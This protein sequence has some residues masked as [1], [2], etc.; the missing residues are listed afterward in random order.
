MQIWR[1]N[2]TKWCYCIECF[3]NYYYMETLAQ[4]GWDWLSTRWH[5]LVNVHWAGNRNQNFKYELQRPF[6]FLM[7]ERS[8]IE[9]L[10]LL[11][12]VSLWTCWTLLY[13]IIKNENWMSYCFMFMYCFEDNNNECFLVQGSEVRAPFWYI[14]CAWYLWCCESF[15]MMMYDVPS[16]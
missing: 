15:S 4:F 8:K 3:H 12:E 16:K 9:K 2:V 14:F 1:W 10:C 13:C 5:C 6:F 7:R 11:V